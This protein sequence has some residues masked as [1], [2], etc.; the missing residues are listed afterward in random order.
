[1][2]KLREHRGEVRGG[3]QGGEEKRDVEVLLID[4]PSLVPWEETSETSEED[5][6]QWA[7]FHLPWLWG[8]LEEAA[9]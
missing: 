1:M 5:R 2:R 8:G 6:Q 9:A 7:L 4:Q 3:Q